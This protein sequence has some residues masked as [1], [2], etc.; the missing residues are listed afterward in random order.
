MFKKTFSVCAVLCLAAGT[1]LAQT[2]DR[3]L[4]DTARKTL[5]TY[6]KGIITLA[7]VIKIEAKGGEIAGSDQEHKTQCVAAFIDPSGL[8]VTSLTNLAPK[9]RINR[10]GGQTLELECQVQ[11]VKYRLTD[12]TE[13]PARVV[14]K[15]EDLD[16]AFLAPLKPLDKATEAKMTVLPLSDSTAQPEVLDSTILIGRTGE[17][18]NYIS[19]LSIG[20]IVSILSTPRTCYLSNVG[21]LGVPVFDHQ[22]KVMGIICRCVKAEGGEGTSLNRSATL[23]N[24]LVLPIADIVKLVPQAKDEMKKPAEG[25][26]KADDAEKK[27]ATSEKKPAASE[28]KPAEPQKKPAEPEKKPAEPEKKPADAQKTE[29]HTV[30]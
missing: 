6:E 23:I 29:P 26:K 14:L 18:L 1:L 7:A 21:G 22:G 28:K 9:I 25:E 5:K 4:V 11:E 8:A 3:Q 13:V 16:L 30:D 17:D 12:G 10:G 2:N 24:Q 27:P 20:R 15:D 19:T